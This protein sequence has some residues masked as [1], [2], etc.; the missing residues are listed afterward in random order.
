[1]KIGIKV[2]L[3]LFVMTVRVETKYKILPGFSAELN[4]MN[5]FNPFDFIYKEEQPGMVL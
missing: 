2:R 1:M 3:H 4:H 5:S